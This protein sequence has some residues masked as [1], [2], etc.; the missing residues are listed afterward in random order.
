MIEVYVLLF[1]CLQIPRSF[2]LVS[3]YLNTLKQKTLVFDGAMGTSLFAYDLSVEDYGGAQFEGCPENLNY[4][5]PEIIQEIHRKFLEAGADVIE[6]NS[7]GGSKIVLAEYGLEDKAYEINKLAARLAREVADEISNEDKPRFVAGSI[8]PGTKLPSLGHISFD[9]LHDSYIPQI[10]GLIDGKADLLIIETC[11]DPLQIKAALAAC[12][13]VFSELKTKLPLQV[14]VT[15]EQVGTLLVGTDISAALTTLCPYPIDII[16]LNCATGPKEMREHVRHLC[17]NAPFYVS[18]IPNAGIPENVGGHAVYPLAANEFAE[19]LSK[20]IDEF[21]V[22]V[23]GGCCGTTYEHIKAL[24]DAVS[25]KPK[26]IRASMSSE[27]ESVESVSSLYS[28]VPMLMEPK[29]LFVGERTNANGSKLFKELLANEDYEGMVEL[30][31]GQLEEGA[32]VLDIC[33]AYVG[34]DEVKDMNALISKV[35]TQVNIPIMIDSTESEVLDS[36][37]KQISAKAIINSVNLED[38]EKRVKEIANLA[39]RYGAALVVLTIDEEGMAKSAEKKFSIAQRLYKLLVDEHGLNPKDLIYDPLT[40]TLGSGD[41]DLRTAGIETINAIRMI[42]EAYPEVKTI[43]GLSNISFGL[44]AK[45]RPALNS[46]FLYECIKAGCDMAICNSKKIIPVS[47]LKKEIKK[48]CEDLIYDRRE[49]NKEECSYDPLMELVKSAENIKLED[50]QKANPYEGLEVEEILAKRIIDGNKTNIEADLGLA[51][52][53]GHKALDIINKFLMDGMKVVGEKFGAGEMQLPFVL[54]SATTMKAAVAYLE[55]FM[56]QSEESGSKGSMVIATV[57]GDVH[58]IGKNL[59]DIILSNNGFKIINLGIKQPIEDII[60]AVKEYKPDAV[61]LSGLLVKS[62]LIMKQGLE[63]LN[64]HD[65][66]VPIILGGAALTRRFVEE[67][68]AN[69]YKGPVFYGFDAFTDLHLM[70]KLCAGASTEEIKQEFYK[71]RT[72]A[73]TESKVYDDVNEQNDELITKDGISLFD[74]T[75]QQSQIKILS[76]NEV[77]KMP[78]YGTKIIESKDI[79]YDA[80]WRYLN[81]DALFIGQWRMGKGKKTKEEYEIQRETVILPTLERVKAIARKDKWLEPKIIYAYY[82]CKINKQNAN[83]LDLYSENYKEII[84]S[85]KFPRQASGDYLCL[86]DYFRSESEFNTIPLQVVSIGQKSADYVQALY[87]AN[88]FQ[89]YL[90]A[91]GLATEST[92]A[93]AEYAHAHIRKELGFSSEDH[94]DPSKVIKCHY[95][96]MRY[97]F[98]YPACPRI[99]DQAQLFR[100]LKPERIGLKLSDEWQIHPDHSTSAMI[101]HHPDAKY[102]NVRA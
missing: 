65:I 40:F 53:K 51:L 100:L 37:L 11:Q 69:T 93:L 56:D 22:D 88:D 47:K 35:N 38:G 94:A 68:C 78:F 25:K 13:D 63:T 92:E 55:Q 96:G 70:E 42:K 3:K 95:H 58:D 30:A 2:W 52:N 81:L 8:G 14:Q 31:K 36:A 89:E 45:V 97:S 43:L 101:V 5:K 82:P 84:E 39:K 21:G 80:M 41:E 15:V 32:H 34:R 28:S 50:T 91:Y 77:P 57:K 6:T 73:N 26:K 102:F 48:Y 72:S 12:A 61:G 59:V 10:K 60:K 4:S 23:V 98:G 90:Y 29:P 44:N 7:F 49:F 85:F 74:F 24:A 46:I 9:D 99:E 83:Q 62:T 66:N 33:T 20:F 79:D 17:E 54:Q 16:G 64:E 19:Q 27:S 87:D 18:C 86:T 67:D 76:E 1:I 71:S 75:E